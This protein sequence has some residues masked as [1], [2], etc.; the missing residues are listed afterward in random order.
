MVASLPW[1]MEAESTTRRSAIK[2]LDLL[3]NR[4]YV[5]IV[6]ATGEGSLVIEVPR[7]A[8]L[9]AGQHVQYVLA[10]NSSAVIARREMRHALVRR[11][12]TS[13]HQR[14]R[15]DLALTEQTAPVPEFS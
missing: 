8:R 12:D 2:L 13:D 7:S 4:Y 10:D 14:L 5:G 11:V 3:T 6:H 1:K 9:N 15:A